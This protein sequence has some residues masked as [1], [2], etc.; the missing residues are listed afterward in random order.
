LTDD[1]KAKAIGDD[2][3]DWC[4]K[5]KA[6]ATKFFERLCE[7]KVLEMERSVRQIIKKEEQ[8]VESEIR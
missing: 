6:E 2:T 3:A 1:F 8:E 7:S 4:V 5:L